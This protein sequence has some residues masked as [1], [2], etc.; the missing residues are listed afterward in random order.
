MS[1]NFHDNGDGEPR[2]CTTTPEKCQFSVHGTE[3]E[4][5]QIAE[6]RLESEMG[7]SNPVTKNK[8]DSSS[9]NKSSVKIAG[10]ELVEDNG[11]KKTMHR[12]INSDGAEG[13]LVERPDL[14]VDS[15]IDPRARV[16]G[17]SRI[18]KSTVEGE[19]TI[20]DTDVTESDLSGDS[21]QVSNSEVTDSEVRANNHLV[22]DNSKFKGS[23]AMST[24]EDVNIISSYAYRTSLV[25]SSIVDSRSV[26]TYITNHSTVE[27]GAVV[28]NSTISSSTLSGSSP[29]AY[30]GVKASLSSISGSTVTAETQENDVQ[31]HSSSIADTKITSTYG[32]AYLNDVNT[33]SSEITSNNGDMYLKTT[34][35][36]SS[37]V[38]SNQDDVNSYDSLIK[39]SS[40]AD[41]N[42]DDSKVYD[43]DVDS[44][45]I[46]ES[47]I[48]NSEVESS[49]LDS[50]DVD[51]GHISNSSV[52]SVGVDSSSIIRSEAS[53]SGGFDFIS[54]AVKDNRNEETGRLLE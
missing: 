41:S 33:T 38:K 14:V 37:T 35:I 19:A 29:H 25:N 49:D 34:D 3:D 10:A 9:L 15:D 17:E 44:S 36:Y 26:E 43:T 31:I 51:D 2:R 28:D 40:V 47:H 11:E 53:S 48:N 42:V 12:V 39:K 18:K 20:R 24:S 4:I 21:L 27:K 8:G 6:D 30:G 13:G 5:R 45:R 32:D 54:M 7:E 46:D 50:A 22:I 16:F 1:N 23:S 52:S